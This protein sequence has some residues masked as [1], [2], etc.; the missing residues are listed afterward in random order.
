MEGM[1]KAMNRNLPSLR[2]EHGDTLVEN[3]LMG[4]EK[5]NRREGVG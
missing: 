4:I 1:V 3:F 2:A 5:R